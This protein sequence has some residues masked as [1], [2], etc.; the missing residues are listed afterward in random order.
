MGLVSLQA[1]PIYRTVKQ[2]VSQINEK[3][4]NSMFTLI[5]L[6]CNT[7]FA[8]V[9]TSVRPR[10][11]VSQKNID[12]SFLYDTGAQR[13]C[14]PFKAF[15]RIYGPDSLKHK[16][17]IHE[18]LNIK[19]AGGNDLGYKGTFMVEMEIFGRQVEHG[20][21]VLEHVQDYILGSDFIH[22]HLLAYNPSSRDF[23]WKLPPTNTGTLKA[24]EHM[25]ISALSSKI[26]KLKCYDSKQ[27][28]MGH[29]EEMVCLIDTGHTLLTGPPGM[30]K[31]DREGNAFTVIQNCGP[32]SMEIS[33]NDVIG[34][35]EIIEANCKKE[36]LDAN[37]ISALRQNTEINSTSE[38]YTREES[39]K[40]TNERKRKHI[41]EHANITVPEEYREQYITLL[42]IAH[43]NIL[44]YVI[45]SAC[46]LGLLFFIFKIFCTSTHS[47]KPLFPS[48]RM[49]EWT[50]RHRFLDPIGSRSVSLDQGLEMQV[51]GV[52]R[53]PQGGVPLVIPAYHKV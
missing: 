27:I 13:T 40:W 35:G 47:R 2:N 46:V 52:N 29:N 23:E 37:F 24:A 43:P 38:T 32:F 6:L 19:D 28:R 9:N 39:D 10:V 1:G 3:I 16:K 50:R 5:T 42:V 30:I 51:N 17:Q 21:V 18:N 26:I 45:I 22:K 49:R 53:T 44:L 48:Y 12:E 25:K 8:S 20:L 31:F 34:T 36:K 33:R 11:K 41:I 4:T 14:M 7:T 15:K